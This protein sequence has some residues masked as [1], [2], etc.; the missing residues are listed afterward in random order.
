MMDDIITKQQVVTAAAQ[1][2]GALGKAL[3]DEPVFLLRASDVWAPV[4]VRHWAALAEES[5]APIEKRRAAHRVANEMRAWREQ[6]PDRVK[7]PD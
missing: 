6:N 4:L 5:G 3:P 2:D 7:A 1:G